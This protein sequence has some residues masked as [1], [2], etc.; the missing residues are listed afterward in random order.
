MADWR[1]R[2]RA[3]AGDPPAAEAPAAV[4]R[5]DALLR[6]RPPAPG[7]PGWAD[8]VVAAAAGAAG[9]PRPVELLGLALRGDGL[10]DA[11][12]DRAAALA[13]WRRVAAALPDEPLAQ[14]YLGDAELAAGDPARGVSLVLAAVEQRPELFL[15]FGWDLE[16]PARQAGGAL[17]FR[18]QLLQ[19][20]WQVR[21]A[22]EHPDTGDEAREA[23]GALLEEHRDA[24]ERLAA[25]RPLGEAIRRLE[26]TGGLPRAMVVRSRRPRG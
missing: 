5:L 17:R 11:P 24:P 10:D 18:W 3:L 8:A 19:L 25:L 4:R 13:L 23:Y 22:A 2:W 1:Q 14:A 16:E 26:A 20:G 6:D 21:A 15:E 12:V 9:E 7:D